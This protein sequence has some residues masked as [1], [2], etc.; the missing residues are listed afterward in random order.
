MTLAP[1]RT[2]ELTA[3]ID[4]PVL[5][6]ALSPDFARDRKCFAASP[7]GLHSSGDGGKTWERAIPF[8]VPYPALTV[9][10]SPDYARDGQLFAGITG[11]VMRSWTY[12]QTWSMAAVGN[13]PATILCLA[14]SP[15]FSQDSV[16]FAGSET[17]GVFR[18]ADR[19]TT[20]QPW[21][22]GL[23]DLQV[24]CLGLSPA[25][26]RDESVF[27]GVSSGVFHSKNGGRAWRETAFPIE[28]AP[29]L[30]LALSPEF[31][32]DGV[33]FAGTESAGL[34]RSADR[35]LTW[36]PIGPHPAQGTVNAILLDGGFATRPHLLI[37]TD[38]G[39]FVSRDSGQSW[40]IWASAP[41]VLALAGE[42]GPAVAWQRVLAG[43]SGG[44]ATWI[45]PDSPENHRVLDN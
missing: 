31:D 15:A 20:W 21:K 17:D 45:S 38:Q 43:L 25:F 1:P 29:V 8:E 16:V 30:C 2:G 5:S 44:G 34:Y 19:G 35:G 10:L 9:A 27:A 13:P 6:V 41:D 32:R 36:T 23:M 42:P 18:S 22:F 37:A 11:G 3:E 24:L 39:L 28:A 40:M 33:L 4:G 26:A 12:G 14:V 7:A